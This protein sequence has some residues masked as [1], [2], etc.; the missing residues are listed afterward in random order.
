MK[1][2]R[3]KSYQ[4]GKYYVSRNSERA[5]EPVHFSYFR[6]NKSSMEEEEIFLTFFCQKSTD[7]Y[8]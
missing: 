5:N 2:A 7:N 1:Y 4:I 6:R 8:L 3:E